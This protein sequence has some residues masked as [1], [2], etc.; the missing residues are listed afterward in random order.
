[1]FTKLAIGLI[2]FCLAAVLF[3][4]LTLTIKMG[5]KAIKLMPVSSGVRK[6]MDIVDKSIKW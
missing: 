2:L 5:A 3:G 6:T 4:V 1:M